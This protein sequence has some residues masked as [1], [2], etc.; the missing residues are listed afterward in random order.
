MIRKNTYVSSFMQFTSHTFKMFLVYS[1]N[2]RFVQYGSFERRVEKPTS[3]FE[4]SSIANLEYGGILQISP[5]PSKGSSA[6][7]TDKSQPGNYQGG[8]LILRGVTYSHSRIWIHFIL[9]ALHQFFYYS[10]LLPVQDA[11]FRT[12][13]LQS[14]TTMNQMESWRDQI[15]G[16]MSIRV[17][18][19]NS[20]R[21]GH[22]VVF[23][24]N[25]TP[26]TITK[27]SPFE[28]KPGLPEHNILKRHGPFK[29]HYN[30]DLK[31]FF[32]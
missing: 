2:Q 3:R 5:C 27:R 12:Q 22:V 25:S 24:I 18:K 6:C 9:M 30:S 10:F 16:R 15:E 7:K 26:G 19:R 32:Y 1:V 23:A 20:K 14:R 28:R 8:L 31:D 17:C 4:Y 11:D 13:H 21:L 29:F